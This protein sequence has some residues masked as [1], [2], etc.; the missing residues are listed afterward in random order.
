MNSTLLGTSV[1]A[2]T[3]LLFSGSSGVLPNSSYATMDGIM[4]DNF[5]GLDKQKFSSMN[6]DNDQLTKAGQFLLDGLNS[7][8]IDGKW[9]EAHGL[10]SNL[11]NG[12]DNDQL[13]ET[14]EFVLNSFNDGGLK[15]QSIQTLLG[16]DESQDATGGGYGGGFVLILVLFILLV[17]VGAGFG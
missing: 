14:T 12:V 8:N 4:K 6:F 7:G 3:A 10:D 11:L 9:L 13:I 16:D 15:K 5:L 2:L 17:I 1:L